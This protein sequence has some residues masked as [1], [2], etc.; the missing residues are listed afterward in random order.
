MV[1]HF[2][3]PITLFKLENRG[4]FRKKQQK[5]ILIFLPFLFIFPYY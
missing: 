3:F 5:E 4:F 1:E 2:L